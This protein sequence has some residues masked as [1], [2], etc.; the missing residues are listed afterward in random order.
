MDNTELEGVWFSTGDLK[1]AISL[2]A[3]GFP[4]RRGSECT[5]IQQR[6]RETFTWHFGGLNDSGES[7]SNFISA[8]EKPAPEDMHRPSNLTVFFL[9]REIMF[10]RTHVIAESHKVP[11][12]HLLQRGDQRLAVTSALGRSEKD[13]LAR[14]AS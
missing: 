14:L 1:L 2:H 7:I 11:A 10:N 3:A 8:W 5:R 4:F 12:H 6:G 13:Q 9:S